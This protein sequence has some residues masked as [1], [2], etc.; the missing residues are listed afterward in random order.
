[1]SRG[2]SVDQVNA[3]V[4]AKVI[5]IYMIY[6]DYDAGA[7]R[8]TSLPY[9]MDITWGGYTWYGLGEFSKIIGVQEQTDGGISPIT[10]EVSGVDPTKIFTALSEQ[11]QGRTCIIYMAFLDD[12]HVMIDE[13]F[14]LF[15]G[16]VDNQT[17]KLGKEGKIAV[18]V[19]NRLARLLIPNVT[20]YNSESQR[21]I[22]PDDKGFEFVEDS[23][24]K[25]VFWGSNNRL[26][27]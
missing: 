11:Y 24:T 17:I 6:V 12:D 15:Q 2:L 23:A 19:K 16:L 5:P 14:I 18:R 4:A 25:E 3:S 10:I 7:W 9:G 20:R 21:A 13:P 22:Y 1:M 8:S 26:R 27:R